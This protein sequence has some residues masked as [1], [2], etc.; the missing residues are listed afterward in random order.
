MFPLR[1]T[2][3]IGKIRYTI[4][5]SNKVFLVAKIDRGDLLAQSTLLEIPEEGMNEFI[6]ALSNYVALVREKRD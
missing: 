3:S 2:V 5:Y 4:G 1:A 6:R